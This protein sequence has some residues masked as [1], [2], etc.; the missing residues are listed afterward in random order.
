[1]CLPIQSIII[2]VIKQIN[3]TPAA[4][5]SDFV[6]HSYDY[7]PNWTSLSPVTMIYSGTAVNLHYEYTLKVIFIHFDLDMYI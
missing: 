7:K 1:M 3:W 6:N 4:W 2:I 5:L